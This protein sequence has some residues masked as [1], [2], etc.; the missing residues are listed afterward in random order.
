MSQD[1]TFVHAKELYAKEL[2]IINY[3]FVHVSHVSLNTLM[4][5]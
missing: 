1:A 3:A 4:Y 2:I 5:L